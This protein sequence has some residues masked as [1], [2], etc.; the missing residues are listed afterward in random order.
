MD[1][2][3]NKKVQY[4]YFLHQAQ[5]VA[6]DNEIAAFKG[7]EETKTAFL[8]AKAAERENIIKNSQKSLDAILQQGLDILNEGLVV[9]ETKAD[10]QSRRLRELLGNS[11]D[12]F[13]LIQ[14]QGSLINRNITIG[15]GG[16]QFILKGIQDAQGLITQLE[17]PIIQSKLLDLLNRA[18]A[19]A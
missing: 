11:L 17:D 5:L 9:T 4:C 15:S 2:Y 6:I 14:A 10:N 3:W 19:R 8:A 18:M 12:P 16:I 13:G 1:R 7:A